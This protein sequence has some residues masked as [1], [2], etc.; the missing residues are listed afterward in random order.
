MRH[1][2]IP[3]TPRLSA[4]VVLVLSC[5]SWLLPASARSR[6][7][8]PSCAPPPGYLG[9]AAYRHL[10]DLSYLDIG[11]RVEGAATTDPAGANA[12]S[13]H[14]LQTLAGGGRVLFDQTGPG[15]M[16]FMRMQEAFGAPWTLS[17]DGRT[18]ATVQAGDLG[19]RQPH[20]FPAGALP[21][22]LSLN[23]SESQG[24]SIIAAAIPFQARMRWTTTRANGNF[25]SI[26]YRLPYGTPLATWTGGEPLGGVVQL[27]DRA[28]TDIAP[29][30]LATRRG[31]ASLRAGRETTL[32]YLTGGPSQIRTLAVQAPLAGMARLGDARLRIYWDGEARPSVD[33][34]LKFLAGDGAGVYLPAGRPL[35]AGLLAGATGTDRT[36]SFNL[37]WPMPF[38]RSARIT[39]TAK[40]PLPRLTWVLGAEPF[41]APAAWWGAF[42]ATYTNVPVPQPGADMT[43]LDVRGSGRIVGT[44][45]NFGSVGPTLEGNPFFYLDDS[46]TPQIAGTGTE[47]WGLGGDYWRGGVQTSLPLGGLPSSTNNPSGTID[48]AAEYRYLVADSIPFNRRALV[49]WQHGALDD[50]TNPYQ[51]VVLWYGTPVQTA[52]LTDSLRLGNR[53]SGAAHVYRARGARI[54]RLSAAY[55]YPMQ[56]PLHTATVAKTTSASTFRLEL[57]PHNVGAFL[58]RTF[59][60][61]VANQ[62]ADVYVDGHFAGA[63]FTAGSSTVVDI[64]GHARRWRDED[65]P[66]PPSLTASRASVTIRIQ[67]TTEPGMPG[68]KWTASQYEMYS[69]VLPACG[70]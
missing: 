37:Y 54:T 27:L 23:P 17:L 30:V 29:P 16:T 48:G 22:P 50:S 18:V 2:L 68:G 47:E 19:L 20:S 31:T 33:A 38:H 44:V 43:F 36:I 45:V 51:A 24:S 12:D 41:T 6:G 46:Q 14:V 62:A 52:R 15:I 32:A 55:A 28:G 63:W 26:Y 8:A 7:A 1:S 40:Q 10:D 5:W 61:G 4:V 59:D 39:L 13:T 49:R 67:P 25:Y 58:R 66:L 69:L 64:Y 70:A 35:V 53:A 34:P 60:Y 11:D 42:H 21:Y 65:F 3:H 56:S 9:L 57:D